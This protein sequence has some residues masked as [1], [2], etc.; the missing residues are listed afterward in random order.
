[1]R[2]CNDDSSKI[3]NGDIVYVGSDLHPSKVFR[4]GF[5]IYE[6]QLRVAK[7]HEDT[8]VWTIGSWVLADDCFKLEVGDKLLATKD[9]VDATE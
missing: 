7:L 3:Q 4:V 6:G 2:V 8:S 5:D 1:M 9:L